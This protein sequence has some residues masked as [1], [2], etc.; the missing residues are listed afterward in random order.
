MNRQ[1]HLKQRM[2]LI[3]QCL[4]IIDKVIEDRLNGEPIGPLDNL[5][6]KFKYKVYGDPSIDDL[7]GFRKHVRLKRNKTNV[8]LCQRR[9]SIELRLNH[10]TKSKYNIFYDDVLIGR[11]QIGNQ[12]V[13]HRAVGKGYMFFHAQVRGGGLIATKDKLLG[14]QL[15]L[16]YSKHLKVNGSTVG[17]VN[18]CNQ[19]SKGPKRGSFI[20]KNGKR[21]MWDVGGLRWYMDIGDHITID[22]LNQVGRY[23]VGFKP[24]QSSI[25]FQQIKALVNKDINN[26]H[27]LEGIVPHNWDLKIYDRQEKKG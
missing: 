10:F 19:L 2:V 4:L 7:Y 3:D 26:L 25:R 22:P 14:G 16:V 9:Q 21:G 27:L 23:V 6:K 18:W 13:Y 12:K 1:D 5:F 11:N 8:A 24:A 20:F 15:A 17:L